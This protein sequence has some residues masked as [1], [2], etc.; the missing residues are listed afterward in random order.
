MG[1]A[2]ALKLMRVVEN[3]RF[4]L[5]IELICAAEAAETRGIENLSRA[6]IATHKLIRKSV[7]KLARDRE[8]SKDIDRLARALQEGVFD[9]AMAH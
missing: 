4:I 6:N 7:P 5:G 9:D 2:A 3:V 8:I 1:P